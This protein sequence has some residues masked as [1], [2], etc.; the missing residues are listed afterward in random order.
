MNGLVTDQKNDYSVC[1]SLCLTAALHDV[2]FRPK[3][4]VLLGLMSEQDH[5]AFLRSSRFDI[6]LSISPCYSE[7]FSWAFFP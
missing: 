6:P 2:D 5:L 4:D 1:S 7:R 3:T